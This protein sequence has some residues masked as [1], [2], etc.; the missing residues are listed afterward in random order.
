MEDFD[1]VFGG[2]GFARVDFGGFAEN[3]KADLAVDDFDQ[4]TVDSAAAGG[5]L[6]KYGGA[7]AI[8][9]ESGANALDLAFDAIDA[10]QQLAAFLHGVGHHSSVDI[11]YPV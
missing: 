5:D 4:Q 3:V 9:F 7:L 8:L 11:L 1:Q 6:L 10:S 2:A